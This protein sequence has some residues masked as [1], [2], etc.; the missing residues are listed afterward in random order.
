MLINNIISMILFY[1]IPVMI[2]YVSI[3]IM[4]MISDLFSNR[5]GDVCEY[6][7][8]NRKLCLFLMFV[9]IINIIGCIGLFLSLLIR[10]VLFGIEYYDKNIKYDYTKFTN[11]IF[12]YSYKKRYKK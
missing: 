7:I 12:R 11:S 1:T 8:T 2:G 6:H 9:P 10:L 5:Y 3:N 4:D